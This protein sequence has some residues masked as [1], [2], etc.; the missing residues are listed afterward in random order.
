MT[1]VSWRW[2]FFVNVPIGVLVAASAPRVLTES[3]RL[4]GRI[5]WAGAV[6]GCGGVA[7]L[8]YGLSKAATGADGVSHW[9]DA[10]V[11]ASLTAA[12]ALLVAFVLIEMRTSRPLLPMR[13]LADRNRSGAYLIMLCIATG[14]FGLFFFLTLFIQTVLGY[15]A[16]RAGVAYL[17]FAVGVVIA[18]GLASQLVPRIGPRP[19]IV[20]GAAMVAGGMFW[21]S[22]L[23]EHASYAGDLLGPQI[24]SSLGL[25][26]VFVPLA[27]VALHKVAEQDSG[28]A[29]SLLNTA[30]QVGGAIG[31]ALLGTIAWT[32]VADSVRTQVAAA[33]RAGRPVPK[34]GTPP[35]ASIYNHALTVGFSRAFAV[36]AGIGLLALLIAI[37]TIRV[38]RQELAGAAPELQQ[39]A[40]QPAASQHAAVQPAVP[41]PGIV[42]RHEDRAVLAAAV[43]PCRL[44]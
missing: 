35:P 19:L 29:S 40:P 9:G 25:G 44:C 5:D 27:L 8:V 32:T 24:V 2:V 14:L 26:L 22:R 38:R 33:A 15:S 30:Q 3:P 18:S 17:P 12:V 37:A 6:T 28:V 16:I 23:T 43:R 41:Q 11:V 42:Q 39:A 7:L 31:L 34:P 36:A 20:V 10:Q 4:P 1:Y 21:F 13:V